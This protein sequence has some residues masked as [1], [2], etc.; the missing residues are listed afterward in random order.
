MTTAAIKAASRIR[1][2]SSKSVNLIEIKEPET[3]LDIALDETPFD[4][5]C[6]V[7]LND[8]CY[9]HNVDH[10][11]GDHFDDHRNLPFL[12]QEVALASV[13]AE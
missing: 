6:Q 12:R 4:P 3:H 13:N 8:S 11:R 1:S 5:A 2:C 9:L 7:I 10:H